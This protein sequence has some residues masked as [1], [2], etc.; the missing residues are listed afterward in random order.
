MVEKVKSCT[1][2][3]IAK[4]NLT[5]ATDNLLDINSMAQIDWFQK[6]DQLECSLTKLLFLVALITENNLI[7]TKESLLIKKHLLSESINS[8]SQKL[9]KIVI[10]FQQ[11]KSLFS[12]RSSLRGSMGMPR[13]RSVD[14]KRRQPRSPNAKSPITRTSKNTILKRQ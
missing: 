3:P 14:Q 6:F 11:T 5:R 4:F 2:S 12:L 1:A 13:A 10:G 9:D 8:K 7:S